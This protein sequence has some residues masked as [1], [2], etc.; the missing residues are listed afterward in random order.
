VG[1]NPVSIQGKY[2]NPAWS[3][4][5]LWNTEAGYIPPSGY[6]ISNP[7][8]SEK[9]Y[10]INRYGKIPVSVKPLEPSDVGPGPINSH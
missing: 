3:N 1:G 7:G 8:L 9:N 6:K 5:I 10:R 4:N 2:K